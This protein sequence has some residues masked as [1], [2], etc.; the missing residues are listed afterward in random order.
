VHLLVC[1]N[2]KDCVYCAERS[3]S[4]HVVKVNLNLLPSASHRA[5][6]GFIVT[7]SMRDFYGKSGTVTSFP[8]SPSVSPVSIIPPM[9]HTH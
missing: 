7:Q 5:G 2:K 6:V 3:E 4:L 8:P 1:D 9:L